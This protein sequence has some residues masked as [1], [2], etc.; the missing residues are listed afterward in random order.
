MTSAWWFV[1]VVAL[2]GLER[3]AELVVSNRNAAW[4]LSRGGREY[5][6]AHY[7]W[8]VVLHSGL[9]LASVVE[10]FVADRPFLPWLGVPMLG[11]VIAAQG[12]R[13]WCIS[14]LGRQWSTRVI[15]VPGLPRV[16][17]G[18]YRWLQ[19]PNYAAVVVEGAALPLVHT[20]WLTAIGFAVANAFLLRTRL[21]TETSALTALAPR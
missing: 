17:H 12:L 13:W 19:H 1:G 9:L 6:Q 15:V 18:P 14:S 16:T 7:P 11:L 4:S 10:V 21:H 20:A 8:M 2:V 5:G 3:L